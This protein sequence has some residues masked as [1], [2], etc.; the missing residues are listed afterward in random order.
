MEVA[1]VLKIDIGGL[2]GEERDDSDELVFKSI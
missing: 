1:W 2:M